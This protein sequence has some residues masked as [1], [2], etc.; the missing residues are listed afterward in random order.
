MVG[1]NLT[2]VSKKRKQEANEA[3]VTIDTMVLKYKR[4]REAA[5][6]YTTRRSVVAS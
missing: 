4:S 3:D 2:P 5:F 6:L 1:R